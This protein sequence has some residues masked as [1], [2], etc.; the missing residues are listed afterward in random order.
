[1]AIKELRLELEEKDKR[2]KA[3]SY[4]HHEGHHT[5]HSERNNLLK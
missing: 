1:M 5:S 3:R 2:S 4:T